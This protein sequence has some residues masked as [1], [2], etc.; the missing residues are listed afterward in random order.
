MTAAWLMCGPRRAAI[1]RAVWLA[2]GMAA[3]A[4]GA[5]AHTAGS[6]AALRGT[7]MTAAVENANGNLPGEEAAPGTAWAD[8]MRIHAYLRAHQA[9]GA[10][11]MACSS[12]IGHAAGS[13]RVER[14]TGTVADPPLRRTGA[15][16]AVA[17]AARGVTQIR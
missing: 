15:P 17:V 13:R 5:H 11:L 14:S 6:A 10:A 16:R 9:A 7:G 1:W 12:L 8:A 3:I 2:W 4:G